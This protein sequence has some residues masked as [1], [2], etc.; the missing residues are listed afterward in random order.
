MNT[1][2]VFAAIGVVDRD[3]IAGSSGVRTTWRELGVDAP[4]NGRTFRTVFGRSDETFRRL[5]PASRALV[6]ACE[7]LGLADVLPR[8]LRHETA[9]VVETSLGCLD[10]DLQFAAS[11]GA[12]MLDAPIFPYTLPSTCLGEIALRHGLRGISVC[13]SVGPGERG[14]ALAEG[15][16]LLANGE[17]PAVLVATLDVLTRHGAGAA[18]QC[19]AIA[20][21]LVHPRGATASAAPWP[22]C[23][24]TA[25]TTLQRA[26]RARR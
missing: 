14:A 21:L 9:L 4:G 26:V 23:A 18:P 20:A 17:A 25:W 22:G 13:L 6:L 11:M 24:P 8:E 15:A 19:A 12:E 7:A 16:R 3:G 1:P 10:A 5:D 2:P